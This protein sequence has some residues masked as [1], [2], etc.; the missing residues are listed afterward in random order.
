MEPGTVIDIIS[1]KL[2]S[3]LS[4][5]KIYG[6]ISAITSGP[7]VTT[8]SFN[9]VP[10]VKIAKIQS[11]AND[12]ARCMST[13]SVRIVVDNNQIGIE[14]PNKSRKIVSLID[15]LKTDSWKKHPGNLPIILGKDMYDE[16]VIVDLASMPHLLIAGTTGSGK[17]IGL[18]TII[19][20][21]LSR[22]T[23]D[24]VRFILIDPKKLEMSQYALIPHL[25][26]P[27][28]TDSTKAVAALRWAFVEMERRYRLMQNLGVQNIKQYNE[29]IKE[30][31]PDILMNRI[32]TGFDDNDKPEYEDVPIELEKLPYI[33]IVI[34]EIANLILQ[35]G[36]QGEIAI[37]KLSQMSR[38]AGIHMVIATQRPSVDV[39]TGTI[40]ANFPTRISFQVQ[41]KIDSR[42]ILGEQG[43]E[44]LIGNGDMMILQGAKITRIQGAYVDDTLIQ[45]LV[46]Q[47][48]KGLDPYHNDAI[49]NSED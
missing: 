41:S 44:Q 34:D 27:V 22:F 46:T 42:T 20:S 12:I 25:L 31:S 48:S 13:S 19:T 39:I 3:V 16:T 47:C 17:S 8:Y 37:Q 18:H 33:V 29:N 21:L 24:D 4:D 5:F 7:T 11:L 14:L 49:V 26:T 40:K 1:H 10:G 6:N 35:S 36:R 38:A 32:Q 30:F 2:E 43:A 15:L 23:S 9:P 28:I 45:E